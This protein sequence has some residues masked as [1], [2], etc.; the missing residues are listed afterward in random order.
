MV[1]ITFPF[2]G[3]WIEAEATRVSG[4]RWSPPD[5]HYEIL[6]I[7]LDDPEDF[8][9]CCLLE[10]FSEGVERMV[11]ACHRQTGKLIPAVESLIRDRWEEE[12]ADK[13]WENF[14]SE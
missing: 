10:D 13:V 7:E 14:S 8:S 11:E 1:R 5:G 3:L 6:S 9:M 12:M 4:D 2:R